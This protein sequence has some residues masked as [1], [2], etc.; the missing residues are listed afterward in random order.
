MRL[1][2]LARQ[3]KV[4]EPIRF[5]LMLP[6]ARGCL[7]PGR[8]QVEWI[9]RLEKAVMGQGRAEWRRNRSREGTDGIAAG[10][11]EQSRGEMPGRVRRPWKEVERAAAPWISPPS[12]PIRSCRHTSSLSPY[13]WT[14]AVTTTPCIFSRWHEWASLSCNSKCLCGR[15]W[16]GEEKKPHFT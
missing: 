7:S 13:M 6:W 9:M 14:F 11:R 3:E 2:R 8:R 12:D 10:R 4:T 5:P 16:P 15:M 1:L